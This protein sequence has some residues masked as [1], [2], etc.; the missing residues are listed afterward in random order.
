M[1]SRC[2][3]LNMLVTL[4]TAG[5]LATKSRCP[6]TICCED[7]TDNQRY[8]V[9]PKFAGIEKAMHRCHEVY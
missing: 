9:P 8:Y 3:G 7:R 6:A 2:R 5:N 1:G 4:L